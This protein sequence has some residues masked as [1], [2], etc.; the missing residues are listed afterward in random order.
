MIKKQIK[1]LCLSAILILKPCLDWCRN[2]YPKCRHIFWIIFLKI[3]V[4]F[5]AHLFCVALSLSAWWVSYWS[6]LWQLWS[7]LFSRTCYTMRDTHTSLYTVQILVIGAQW[8][9]TSAIRSL[10]H[11]I[12]INIG[13]VNK[14][15]RHKRALF[16]HLHMFI[17]ILISYNI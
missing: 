14:C 4:P 16:Y 2:F 17:Y 10:L 1:F 8:E 13:T 11:V 7:V 6:V 5:K 12:H 3:S 15:W 9:L